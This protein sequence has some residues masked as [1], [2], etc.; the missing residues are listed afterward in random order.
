MDDARG[1]LQ[2]ALQVLR[3]MSDSISGDN[4]NNQLYNLSIALLEENVGLHNAMRRSALNSE[5]Y[6]N[7][8]RLFE[9]ELAGLFE[10]IDKNVLTRRGSADSRRSVIDQL[11]VMLD[12]CGG[13][14]KELV[15]NMYADRS[16][17]SNNLSRSF[18]AQI[19]IPLLALVSAFFLANNAV[20]CV[21][22]A[23][24]CLGGTVFA[25]N[26]SDDLCER[27]KELTEKVEIFRRK[28]AKYRTD[29]KVILLGDEL[30]PDAAEETVPKI[31]Q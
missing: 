12:D 7:T 23:A 30:S 28:V 3:N 17:A 2:Q 15:D 10:F 21:C 6:L 18:I 11:S 5:K 16:K 4:V 24:L 19:G 1:S 14:L 13:K 8:L 26:Y 25:C 31:S 27:L 9:D 29:V 22:G 20:I